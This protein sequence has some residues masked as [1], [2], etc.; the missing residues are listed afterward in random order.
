MSL[1][2]RSVCAI[3]GQEAFVNHRLLLAN[4]EAAL[5][6]SNNHKS[7]ML[8]EQLICQSKRMRVPAIA[9][10]VTFLLLSGLIFCSHPT[11][12][13]SFPLLFQIWQRLFFSVSVLLSTLMDGHDDY[14]NSGTIDGVL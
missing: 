11:L 12:L 4:R 1:A 5:L 2:G 3:P 10:K 9:I 13:T 14:T 6:R 7:T 8:S